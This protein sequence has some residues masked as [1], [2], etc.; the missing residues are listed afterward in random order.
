MGAK[1]KPLGLGSLHKTQT[2]PWYS[3]TGLQYLRARWYEPA[4][5]RFTQ[6]DPFPGVM[7]MP[8]TQHPYIYGL[9]NPALYTDPSGEFVGLVVGAAIAG[10]IG[11]AIAGGAYALANPGQ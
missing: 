6:V 3:G 2:A 9:N 11:G 1:Q 8:R 10:L 5:G 7:S 4:V